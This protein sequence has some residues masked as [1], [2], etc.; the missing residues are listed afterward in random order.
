MR[1]SARTRPRSLVDA[2][3]PIRRASASV[4]RRSMSRV[5]SLRAAYAAAPVRSLASLRRDPAAATPVVQSA[6]G[7]SVRSHALRGDAHCG[8]R[9]RDV[10]RVVLRCVC[11]VA[12]LLPYSGA[13]PRVGRAKRKT[14]HRCRVRQWQKQ[15]ARSA[16]ADAFAPATAERRRP[17]SRR[18]RKRQRRIDL[19]LISRR[20]W[21]RSPPATST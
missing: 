7:R 21:S 16:L 2:A 17:R 14:R 1:R 12:P 11:G 6:G 15:A 8:A 13:P 3:A 4:D 18:A 5:R 19:C 10:S 20:E 9:E